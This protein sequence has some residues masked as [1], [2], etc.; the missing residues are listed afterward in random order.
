MNIINKEVIEDFQKLNDNTLDELINHFL[1]TTPPKLKKMVEAYYLKDYPT[2]RKEA[3]LVRMSSL[4]LGAEKLTE[5]TNDIEFT[6]L[7][8][9]S[10][11]EFMHEKVVQAYKH[12]ETLKQELEKISHPNSPLQ[13]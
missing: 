11:D 7:T 12:F 9:D 2:V 1:Q 4:T 8:E 6:T 3:H 5:L 13:T 10:L